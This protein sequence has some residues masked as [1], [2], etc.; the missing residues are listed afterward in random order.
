MLFDKLSRIREARIYDCKRDVARGGCAQQLLS[1]GSRGEVARHDERCWSA[2]LCGEGCH[3]MQ[4]VLPSGREQHGVAS[5]RGFE[6]YG[7]ADTTRRACHDGPT[8]RPLRPLRQ[9][10]CAH[11]QREEGEEKGH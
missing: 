7:G 1:S 8:L 10:A 4:L 5:T 9:L 2:R 3:A 6:R 11:E